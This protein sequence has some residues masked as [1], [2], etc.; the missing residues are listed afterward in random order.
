MQP[1]P[2]L[3]QNHPEI[4][5][6]IFAT[7]LTAHLVMFAMMTFGIAFFARMMLVPRAFVLPMVIVFSVI[8]AFALDNRPFDIGVML[9]FGLLGVLLELAKVPL[10]PFVVG[11]VL[12]PIAESELRSGLMS[13]AGSFMPLVERPMACAM[14]SIAAL[15]F[16]WPFVREW[17]SSARTSKSEKRSPS[18]SN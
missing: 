16:M 5:N 4:V 13:S 10:A 14:L 18:P 17:R 3:F 9:G 12:A 2:L 15:L 11:L 6:T 8:G 7:H 1:G